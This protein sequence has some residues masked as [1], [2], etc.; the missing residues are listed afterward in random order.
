MFRLLVS[1]LR[2]GGGEEGKMGGGVGWG[3]GATA[4]PGVGHVGDVRFLA[5]REEEEATARA[6]E[7][8]DK[9]GNGPLGENQ[10]CT[11]K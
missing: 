5:A 9:H 7:T 11:I 1:V 10:G 4:P 3:C 6:R 2:V 8:A